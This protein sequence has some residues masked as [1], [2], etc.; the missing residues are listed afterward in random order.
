MQNTTPESRVSSALPEDTIWQRSV[1][2]D[3]QSGV[4]EIIRAKPPRDFRPNKT[5]EKTETRATDTQ[6][7]NSQQPDSVPPRDDKT[8]EISGQSKQTLSERMKSLQQRFGGTDQTRFDPS[9]NSFAAQVE[10]EAGD[11]KTS[12]PQF[13]S[14]SDVAQRLARRYSQSQQ[15]DP[16]EDV[17]PQIEPQNTNL[18]EIQ[19]ASR[20]IQQDTQPKQLQESTR[21]FLEP[22]I[23]FDP[24]AAKIFVSPQATAFTTSLNADAATVASDVYLNNRFDEQSPEGLGLLAHELTHVGQ[25]LQTAFVPPILQDSPSQNDLANE[26]SETQARIVEARVTNT[27]SLF[28]PGLTLE[29][30]ASRQTATAQIPNFSSQAQINTDAWDGLPAPWEAMPNL[31]PTSS[32]LS[33]NTSSSS[34]LAGVTPVSDTS[35]AGVQLAETGRGNENPDNEPPGAAAGQPHPPAQD[36]DLL[37]QQVYEILKRRLSSERRREG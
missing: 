3:S 32:N 14:I 25:N 24:R 27:A 13:Q 2:G 17:K 5:E 23:G 9:T 21:N 37:A 8:A 30:A 16:S 10:S 34:S 29:T 19:A 35:H 15:P 7:P 22:L 18:A 31:T 26:S 20:F 36:M 12:I 11:A 4:V 6:Q 1:P 28:V 33:P